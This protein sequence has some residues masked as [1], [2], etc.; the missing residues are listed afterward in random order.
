MAHVRLA[1]STDL[2]TLAAL[3]RVAVGPD[4]YVLE[5]LPEMVARKEILVSVVR[6]RVRAM[7]GLTECADGALWIGQLR[8]HPRWRRR[9]LAR[10]LLD[11]AYAR[12]VRERRPALRLW[13]SQ[14]NAA[15]CALFESNGFSPVAVFSRM[16][17]RTVAGVARPRRPTRVPERRNLLPRWERSV[18]AKEG[19]GFLDYRWRFT[20][21]ND[22]VIRDLMG[23]RELQ[24]TARG[25]LLLWAG[26]ENRTTVH[27]AALTGGKAALTQARRAAG[28]RGFS[29]VL[30]FL[31]RTKRSLRTARQAGFRMASWGT[32]AVLYER[33]APRVSS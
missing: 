4:D 26:E 33:P 15:A 17:A 27:V 6:G 18:F 16:V 22:A 25:T 9:G 31:P 1:G 29:R 11:H 28:T 7:T 32:R 3:C 20:R 19:R 8:S 24:W 2:R 21:L 12:V 5:Y 23:R 13:T 10:I 14:R 30:A